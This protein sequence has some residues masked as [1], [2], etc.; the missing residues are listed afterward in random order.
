[1][2][3]TAEMLVRRSVSYLTGGEFKTRV[4]DR[5]VDQ[6][7]VIAA[8]LRDEPKAVRFVFRGCAPA[9]VKAGATLTDS[10]LQ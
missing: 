10:D 6:D 1:M 2:K 9:F 8:V 4:V 3:L 7:E 5:S